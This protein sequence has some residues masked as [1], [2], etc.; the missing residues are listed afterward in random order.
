MP[1][2]LLLFSV[3]LVA[4]V[5][6]A[7]MLVRGA[8]KL[9][10]AWGI[11]PLI[12]GLTVVA[13][14]TSTPELAVSLK[15]TLAGQPD[16][17][18]GNVIG[19]NIANVLLILGVCALI[20]PLEVA[21]QLVRSDVWIMLGAS[22][23]VWALASDGALGR[24]DG[25]L[26]TGILALYTGH[27]LRAARRGPQVQIRLS[28]GE[29]DQRSSA[30]GR[31]QKHWS[32]NLVF[33][34]IGLV[35]LIVG[36]GWLIDASLAIGRIFEIS[37]LILGLTVVAVGTSLPELATSFVASLRGERDIAVGNVVGSNIFNLVGVLGF[38][39]A[40]SPVPINIAES[41][42]QFDI[43][44]MT[45]VAIA[46]LPIFFS[47]Y[48]I[49]RWEGGL[50]LAYYVAYVAYLVL[51]ASSHEALGPFSVVM[52]GFV[53]PLT[54]ATLAIIAVRSWRSQT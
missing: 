50:F 42:L 15:A 17:S 23:L 4:L 40:L 5:A 45:A 51:N 18:V 47:G 20:A 26:L 1:T 28:E 24:W 32:V 37:E 12:I 16:L 25:L 34:V 3:G 27:S 38:S 54:V 33:V 46:C 19:S 13:Y 10:Q 30:G 14:G 44:V 39:A 36:S 35:L 22:V 31:G 6:G 43:P 49:D 53:V 41:A 29:T 21:L 8:S 52:L 2:H 7:E 48:R 9:A 11:A